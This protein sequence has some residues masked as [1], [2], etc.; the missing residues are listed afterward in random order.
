MF[1]IGP[2]GAIEKSRRIGSAGA[3]DVDQQ[4]DC[5]NAQRQVQRAASFRIRAT[6][7]DFDRAAGAGRHSALRFGYPSGR[8]G[9]MTDQALTTIRG[10][11]VDR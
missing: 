11:F 8:H 2:T 7:A 4:I 10:L 9:T 5:G 6:R 1:W 3:A